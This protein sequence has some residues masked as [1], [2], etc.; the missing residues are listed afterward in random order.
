MG[1]FIPGC[2]GI[3]V[4]DVIKAVNAII[5]RGIIVAHERGRW[6]GL[7]FAEHIFKVF[8]GRGGFFNLWFW[9]WI[10]DRLGC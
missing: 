5:N 10:W 9:L 8:L 7:I 3:G 4:W 6:F 2:D 1:Y